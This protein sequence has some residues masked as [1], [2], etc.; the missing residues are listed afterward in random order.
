M[1]LAETFSVDTDG[2][3]HSVNKIVV[4]NLSVL[5]RNTKFTLSVCERENELL[6]FAFIEEMLIG[7]NN[8]NLVQ[9]SIMGLDE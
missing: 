1:I 8:V 9:G 2:P 3:D 7:V 5:V 6:V 4:D